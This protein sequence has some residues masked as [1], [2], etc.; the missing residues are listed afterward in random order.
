MRGYLKILI[1]V[2]LCF[3]GFSQDVSSSPGW[4]Y[5]VPSNTIIEAGLNYSIVPVSAVNQTL[6]S[7][8][9]LKG[10]STFEVMV[11]KVDS[12]WNNLLDLQVQ[13]TGTGNGGSGG[14]INGGETYI[15]ITNTPQLFFSGFN[16][17]SNVRNN[18]PI[19][20]RLNGISVLVPV[21]TYTTTVVYTISN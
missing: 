15:S 8:S 7:L 9:R 5:S 3:D 16:F 10:S 13:R 1:L 12:D 19:Q 20:Y 6:I 18:I 2:L 11:N 4:T 21:K 17:S 14:A